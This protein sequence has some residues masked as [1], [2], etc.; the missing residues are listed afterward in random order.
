MRY[1]ISNVD[2]KEAEKIG[3]LYFKGP[4]KNLTNQKIGL[5]EGEI[6]ELDL[7]EKDRKE[8][9]VL[10]N[11]YRGIY[12]YI[13]YN[14]DT[15]KLHVKNDHFGMLPVY[16]FF[17]KDIFFLSNNV[18]EIFRNIDSSNIQID[19]IALKTPLVLYKIPVEGATFFHSVSY[20]PAASELTLQVNQ[21]KLCVEKYWTLS[22]LYKDVSLDTAVRQLDESIKELFQFLKSRHSKIKIGFGNSGGIDS[23]IIP[24]YAKEF[25]LDIKGFIIGE[26]KPRKLLTATSHKSAHRIAKKLD[27][28]HSDVSFDP[29][30]NLDNR[31]FLDIRNNPF[32]S[33]QIFKNPYD[34][35]PDI[36]C[37]IC[38]GDG[39]I[40]SNDS[41]KWKSLQNIH[42]EEELALFLFN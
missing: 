6:M 21:L 35:L 30:K 29:Y 33:S 40:V 26:K 32:S 9:N 13:E 28:D 36:D 18:W 5:L 11:N 2:F 23:R 41:N 34:K 24:L 14:L 19:M 17:N 37:L 39:F 25:G 12:N 15:E 4:F 42:N 1:V 38:G 22:Q 20:L 3:K 16:V 10:E 8:W 31:F 27:F 7:V